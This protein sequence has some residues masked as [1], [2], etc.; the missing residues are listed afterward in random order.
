MTGVTLVRITVPG[1]KCDADFGG[2]KQSGSRPNCCDG[3]G[4]YPYVDDGKR[5]HVI[6]ARKEK[7]PDFWKAEGRRCLRLDS[8]SERLTPVCIQSRRDVYR[9]DG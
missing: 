7:L 9:K 2:G 5:S 8:Y 3:L 1:W 4:R 6:R